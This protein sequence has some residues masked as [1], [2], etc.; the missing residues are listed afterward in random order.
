MSGLALAIVAA[1]LALDG[2]DAPTELSAGHEIGFATYADVGVFE[3]TMR[4]RGIVP[5]TG[6]VPIALN[7]K[8]D[9]GRD[10]W[11]RWPS[12]RIDKA[13]V[14]DCAQEGHYQARLDN[15]FVVEVP[16]EIAKREGFYAWGPWPV[17]VWYKFPQDLPV[18]R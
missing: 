6:T 8:G 16:A 7:A 2:W 13:Q 1:T 18:M 14:V 3:N 17:E 10:V 12:G 4:V 5:I 11:L 9:L 15:L